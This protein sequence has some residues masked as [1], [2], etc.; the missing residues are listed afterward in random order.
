M[1]DRIKIEI[2][3]RMVP[4]LLRLSQ[5]QGR[6]P[7]EVIEE[8]LSL[9]FRGLGME[10]GSDIGRPIRPIH[11]DPPEDPGRF[12]SLEELF[13]H[14]DKRRREAG[15]EPLSEEEA[16][17]LAVEEQHAWRRER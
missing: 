5:E 4:I 2:E 8:A 10:L 3:G 7:D 14:V 16:I 15:V 12:D 13:E 6:D 17:R 9:Y 11:V 1:A